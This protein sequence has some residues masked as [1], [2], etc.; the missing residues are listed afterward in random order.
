[1]KPLK[2]PRDLRMFVIKT[3]LKRVVPC[4]LLI[5]TFA[6]ALIFWGDVILPV[7]KDIVKVIVYTMVMLVP[8][9]VTGVPYKMIDS[10]WK[11]EVIESR[12]VEE[13]S[14][15]KEAVPRMYG[16]VNVILNVKMPNGKTKE[17]KLQGS[18]FA[19]HVNLQFAASGNA[20]QTE[21]FYSVGNHVFHL[22][23]SNQYVVLPKAADKAVQCPICGI[24]ND[25]T[26]EKCDSCG[27]SLVID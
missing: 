17:I 8:F 1:M 9:A 2:L 25:K 24:K 12:I 21:D 5:V 27:H 3:V 26:N 23:G 18:T 13:T 19:K 4:M 6:I 16:S 20:N 11:G 22:Y 10:T 14:F 15:T 7:D